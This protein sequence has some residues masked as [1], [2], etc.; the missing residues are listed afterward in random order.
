MRGR[1]RLLWCPKVNQVVEGRYSESVL[2][3][4]CDVVELLEEDHC[5]CY[6]ALRSSMLAAGE[7]RRS[8]NLRRMP[9]AWMSFV[10]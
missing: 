5:C 7:R 3:E 1:E 10:P 6:C 4:T 2:S 9:H 8:N